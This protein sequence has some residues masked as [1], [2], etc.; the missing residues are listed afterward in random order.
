MVAQPLVVDADAATEGEGQGESEGDGEAVPAEAAVDVN[1]AVV[2]A[3]VE[4]PPAPVQPIVATAATAP[5]ATEVAAQALPT[6]GRTRPSGQP[7]GAPVPA[8]ALPDASAPIEAASADG[9]IVA[10]DAETEAAAPET[11]R[12]VKL[13]DA[14]PPR[15]AAPASPQAPVQAAPQVQAQAQAAPT[16]AHDPAVTA[17]AADAAATPAAD[18]AQAAAAASAPATARTAEAAQPRKAEA[19]SD[20][21]GDR[22]EAFAAAEPGQASAA[23]RVAPVNAKA[24]AAKPGAERPND[25]PTPAAAADPTAAPAAADHADSAIAHES[26]STERPAQAAAASAHAAAQVRGSPETVASLSAQILKKLDGRTTRFDVQL[27][28][29]GLGMVDVRV[30]IGQHGRVSAAL[31]FENPQAAQELKARANDLQK[32]L[33]QAG[34]DL[35]GG[36]SFDVAGD[37]GRPS[38][39][40]LGGD[41]QPDTGAAF[42]GKAFRAALDTADQADTVAAGP[43][44]L[45]RGVTAGLDVRI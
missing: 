44:T 17:E 31:A 29:E 10:A 30:E 23:P 13:P 41:N 14:A 19:R 25:I 21:G 18:T 27:T 15:A 22:V 43:L 32:A 42:R 4:T 7:V 39:G 12:P 37:Q 35:S 24:E 16:E 28:P 5:A 1:A 33:E 8:E 26:P 3:L 9:E 34:F 6:E 38:H 20:K 45:R 40:F 11:A 36:M 2:A